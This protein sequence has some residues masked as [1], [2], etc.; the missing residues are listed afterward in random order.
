MTTK[1]HH[2]V[3][4]SYLS[5]FATTDQGKA[6]SIWVYDKKANEVRLQPI[7]DTAVIGHFYTFDAVPE[8]IDRDWLE[9]VFGII[10]SKAMPIIKRWGHQGAVPTVNEIPDVA[11]FLA[12][13]Y[14]RVPRAMEVIQ[15]IGEAVAFAKM[16]AAA[17]DEAKLDA[18]I[19]RF[20]A[21]TQYD[22]NLT[23]EEL[24]ALV[25]NFEKQFSVKVDPKY[26]LLRSIDQVK[27]VYSRLI[28]RDWCLCDSRPF[29]GRFMTC[30]A[31]VNVF[32]YEDGKAAFFGGL[33]RPN[34]E[35]HFPLSPY[36][37]ISLSRTART[38]KRKASPAFVREINR[39]TAYQ[40]QR[41]I[42]SSVKTRRVDLLVQDSRK[43]G[44][45]SLIDKT[46]MKGHVKTGWK[47]RTS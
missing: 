14:V 36:V 26:A 32:N 45:V 47:T 35:I 40:A 13:L 31:P 25:R 38:K 27:T 1:R 33:G 10:E 22:R 17:E 42:F 18:L 5:L 16:E 46:A 21:D 41:Y 11:W 24:K 37:C 3:T 9:K 34:V 30:D 43:N 15:I 28:E 2:Y 6:D 23:R 39:R 29:G 4:R 19:T 8:G 44:P 20:I 12:C 7:H